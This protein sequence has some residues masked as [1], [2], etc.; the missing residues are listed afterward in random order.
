MKRTRNRRLSALMGVILG[1]FF[2][3][4][5]I[6]G[7]KSLSPDN[8]MTASGAHSK[9]SSTMSSAMFT[10]VCFSTRFLALLGQ[11]VTLHSWSRSSNF[12]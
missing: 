7:N 6:A 2:W 3:M 4:I 9:A 5:F 10:S 12:P 8:K 1:H 11:V